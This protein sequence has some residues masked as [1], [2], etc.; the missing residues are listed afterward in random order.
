MPVT[1]ERKDAAGIERLLSK[2]PVDVLTMPVAVDFDGDLP[3]RRGGEHAR[4]LSHDSSTRAVYAASWMPEHRNA[5]RRHRGQH[6]RRLVLTA[7][8]QRMRRS[9]DV[10]ELAPLVE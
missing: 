9:H 2:G 1:I 8:E 10:L 6:S 4:P 5:R 7:T 3:L